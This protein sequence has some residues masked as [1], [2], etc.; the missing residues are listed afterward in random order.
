MRRFAALLF[1]LS[2]GLLAGAAP[3]PASAQQSNAVLKRADDSR[4]AG[5]YDRAIAEATEAIKLNGK[6]AVSYWV[7]GAAYVGRND[8]DQAIADFG[9]SRTAAS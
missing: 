3:T 4:K 7:R 1:A 6:N 2:L 8:Y 5:Q 9:L